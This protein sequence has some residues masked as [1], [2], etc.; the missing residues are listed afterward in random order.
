[1]ADTSILSTLLSLGIGSTSLYFF[2]LG[3]TMIAL[4][5]FFLLII[6]EYYHTSRE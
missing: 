5:L 4:S 1:M 2:M 3:M 6:K